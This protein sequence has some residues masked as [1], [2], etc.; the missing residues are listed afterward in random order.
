MYS[1]VPNNCAANLTV[2]WNLQVDH[3]FRQMPPIKIRGPPQ[4][5][6]REIVWMQRYQIFRLSDGHVLIK[7]CHF[8]NIDF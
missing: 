5:R 8:C 4:E 2:V 3:F 7:N 6:L 1:K